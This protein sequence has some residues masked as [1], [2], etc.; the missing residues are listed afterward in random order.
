M[1]LSNFREVS[2]S[3]VGAS[4][5]TPPKGSKTRIF[6]CRSCEYEVWGHWDTNRL[7]WTR[8]PEP[9]HDCGTRSGM[10][11]LVGHVGKPADLKGMCPGC[12]SRT[13]FL[14]ELG[15][16]GDDAEY[17]CTACHSIYDWK[18]IKDWRESVEKAGR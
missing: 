13:L 17:L 14:F 2:Y 8:R 5:P 6:V 16:T 18:A 15:L 12:G 3:T 10:M 11:Q 1:S 9:D 7:A 4:W